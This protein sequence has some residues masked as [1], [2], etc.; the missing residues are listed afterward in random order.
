[1]VYITGD[2]HGDF[3][4]LL[5]KLS[6]FNINE[7][8]VVIILGDSGLNYYCSV[9]ESSDVTRKYKQ[10]ETGKLM[11]QELKQD[12]LEILGCVPYF[13]LIQGNHE[14]P[15]WLVEKYNAR[16]WNGGTVYVENSFQ[17][18]LFAKNGESFEIEG[19][20]YLV[21]GGAYSV[22]KFYR[23]SRKFRWFP[24]EQMTDDEKEALFQKIKTDSRYDIVLSHT[25]PM[26]YLPFEKFLT[27]VNQDT[28]DNS[29][30]KF[31]STVESKIE[32]KTWFAGHFHCNKKYESENGK[33]FYIL[34]DDVMGVG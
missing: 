25:V 8:D 5:R 3:H 18:F 12:C 32:Y 17:K 14:A 10:D 29:M 19:K 6:K 11:K 4:K 27:C 7:K 24:E 16:Q 22:D 28:V 15:A 33:V 9:N 1:M 21:I 23:L 13:L 2:T 20:K 31:L 30:E 26:G 34:F